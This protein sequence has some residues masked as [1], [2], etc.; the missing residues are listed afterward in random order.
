M[1]HP[2]IIYKEY[3]THIFVKYIKVATYNVFVVI[4]DTCSM[5]LLKGGFK[6]KPN[7]NFLTTHCSAASSI[8]ILKCYLQKDNIRHT[9]Y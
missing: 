5:T 3:K 4:K 8:G 7:N 9:P 6:F 2:D 1:Q